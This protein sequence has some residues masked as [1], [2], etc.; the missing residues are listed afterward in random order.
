[1]N[2]TLRQA[3]IVLLGLGMASCNLPRGG[4]ASD[5]FG[6][7]A[8]RRSTMTFRVRMEVE[9]DG[10]SIRYSIGTESRRTSANRVWSETERVT[11]LIDTPIRLEATPDSGRPIRSVR[12]WVD[13]ELVDEVRCDGCEDTT[14][15]TIEGVGGRTMSV[16]TV[17]RAR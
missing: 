17:L 16:K 2:V 13:G 4:T 12:L 7:A 1:M 3:L 6:R 11:P 9:C 5:P 15:S 14:R 8:L 10:C